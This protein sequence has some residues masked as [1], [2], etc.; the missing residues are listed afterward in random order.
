MSSDNEGTPVWLIEAAA[1]GKPAAST[2]VGGVA[3][4]VASDSGLVVGAGDAEAL[5]NAIGALS[6]D[7]VAREQMGAKARSHVRDRFSVTRLVH[8]MDELYRE[9]L[10]ARGRRLS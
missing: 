4:V 8:S 6:T 7:A 9:L 3:D 5:S 1:A 10:A 2:D